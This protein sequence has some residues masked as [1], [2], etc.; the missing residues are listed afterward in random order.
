MK[1]DMKINS[2]AEA[3]T[4]PG[5]FVVVLSDISG[6]KKIPIIIKQAEA[7]FITSKLTNENKNNRP[8]IQDLLKSLIDAYNIIIKEVVIYDIKN[9]IY[10]CKIF[11]S[12][13]KNL[14]FE[15]DCTVGDA[16]SIFVMSGCP[17]YIESDV[18]N[19]MAI[20]MNVNN[21][22]TENKKTS[23]IDLYKQ[24]EVALENEDYMLAAKLRDK[25]NNLKM[26]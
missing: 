10:Y 2:L 16:L 15:L 11:T 5:Y 24:M 22:A 4:K 8:L 14:K 13:G 17:L 20:D 6:D 26:V 9:D 7:S 23:N 21:K 12:N 25:I 1:I 19:M 18:S 3:K